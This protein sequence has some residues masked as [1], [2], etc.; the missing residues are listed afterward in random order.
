M[1]CIYKVLF[2]RVHPGAEKV[3]AWGKCSPRCSPPRRQYLCGTHPQ[4]SWPRPGDADNGLS[5]QHRR[6]ISQVL[7]QRSLPD[8]RWLQGKL[9]KVCDRTLESRVRNVEF[10]HTD[11]TDLTDF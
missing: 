5:G 7:S 1:R 3:N 11:L 2:T 4:G 6:G 9:R 10:S 8:G